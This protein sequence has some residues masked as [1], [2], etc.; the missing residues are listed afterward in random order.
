MGLQNL[1]EK[2]ASRNRVCSMVPNAVE[3]SS[4]MRLKKILI[5]YGNVC[6]QR[7]VN[8][9][10]EWEMETRLNGLKSEGRKSFHFCK[11]QNS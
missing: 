7:D 3:D 1:R 2:I 11:W 6:G 4:K 8:Q 10:A 5:E 9:A